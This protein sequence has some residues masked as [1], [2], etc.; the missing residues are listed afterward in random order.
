MDRRIEQLDSIRG[1]AAFSVFMSHMPLAAL[2]VPA[3][4]THLYKASGIINGHGAVM[5]FF[6]LSGFVLSIPF[7]HKPDMDYFPYLVKRFF[8]IYVPYIFAISFA[9]ALSQLLLPFKISGLSVFLDNSWK[10]ALN[11]SLI[12]E[13]I[14]FIGNIHSDSFNG[15]I[16]SLI[17]ELRISIIF[18]FVVLLVRRLDWKLCTLFCLLLS[19]ISG[20]NS[21]LHFQSPNGYL[22]TYFDT[23][24]FLSI[25][26][27]GSIL[28]KHRKQVERFIQ[29]LSFTSKTLF[30]IGSLF[31]YNFSGV[32]ASYCFG[33]I[34]VTE[35]SLIC[36]QYGMAMGAIGFI[37]MAL[38]SSK[39]AGFLMNKQI[40]F[41]GKISFSLYL[42]H[43]PVL[44]GC[45]HLFNGKFPLWIICIIA[46]VT[47]IVMSSLAYRFIE[48]PS[49]KIG[50][51][52]ASK[53]KVK[54]QLLHFVRRK[55]PGI[56]AE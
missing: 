36:I 17:H 35:P 51:K 22:V 21:L 24:N 33:L 32:I 5:L 50:R 30:L 15:V 39:I 53:V 47:G 26:I 29:H 40:S 3:L 31:M 13:H 6:V 18:P 41:L 11:L 16:W 25:F 9:I 27:F 4:L 8:R 28:A 48:E 38:G 43:P 46:I 23:L 55:A 7:L 49:M 1:L 34:G 10:T 45:I 52:L 12:W 20:L 14:Y 19:T 2:A 42:Y 56:P 37:A 44:L 54:L